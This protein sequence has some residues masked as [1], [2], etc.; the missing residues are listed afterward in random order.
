MYVKSF[1]LSV[2][3]ASKH[4][5]LR[6]R[7]RSVK[8]GRISKIPYKEEIVGSLENSRASIPL[9]YRVTSSEDSRESNYAVVWRFPHPHGLILNIL[10]RI[11]WF[12]PF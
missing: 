9:H 5:D 3:I 2:V 1:P 10:S 4:F 12:V 6:A 11:E 8:R 7:G